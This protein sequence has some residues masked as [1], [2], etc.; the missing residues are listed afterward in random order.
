MRTTPAAT[1]VACLCAVPAAAETDV[2]HYTGRL[3]GI[4]LLDIDFCLVL[5]PTTYEAGMSARTVGLVDLLF[6]GRAAGHAD[7]AI[8]ATGL[9]P[10]AYVEHGRLS[11]EEHRV[12]IDYPAGSSTVRS[13]IVRS[14]EPPEQ[15]YRL[16]IP[17]ADLPGAIDGLSA[18]ALETLVATRTGACQGG[19]LVF[20][21]LQL[22]RATTSTAGRETLAHS[23][24]SV[25]E[26]PALRCDTT[27]TMV[28]G[29]MK[30]DSIPRQARPRHSRGWLA[31]LSPGA[32]AMPIRLVFDADMLGDVVVDLDAVSHTRAAACDGRDE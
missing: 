16:P 14:I 9:K 2:L 31:P 29:F 23:S 8:D 28:A 17:A 20:D 12:A 26:G 11:G 32:P 30:D 19:A 24:H 4:A 10:R 18:I 3:H 6:H 25:F 5:T 15:K 27:S 1:L 13:P 7:G 22:R 21:G